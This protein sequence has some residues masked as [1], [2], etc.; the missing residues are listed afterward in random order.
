MRRI[1]RRRA[2]RSLDYGGHLIVVDCSRSS[3]PSLVQ[4][5]FDAIRQESPTPL[6]D[7]VL[8]E[9]EF[10]GDRFAQQAIGASQD[11]VASLRK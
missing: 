8:V 5:A 6:P 3:W 11:D 1:L 9:P 7:S 10:I 4:Q 2:Q